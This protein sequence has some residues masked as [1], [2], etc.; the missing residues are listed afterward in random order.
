MK[1]SINKNE[2]WVPALLVLLAAAVRL[3]L[4]SGVY[5]H[6]DWAYLFYIRS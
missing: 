3:L 1:G 2:L 4:F 5:G 6:D